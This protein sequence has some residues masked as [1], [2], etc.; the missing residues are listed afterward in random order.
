MAATRWREIPTGA[1]EG[2]MTPSRLWFGFHA[3]RVMGIG[4]G[5]R[6]N[7]DPDGSGDMTQTVSFEEMLRSY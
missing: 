6:C 2:P 3:R 4:T 7:G 5:T 1:A